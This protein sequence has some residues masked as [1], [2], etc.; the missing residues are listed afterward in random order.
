MPFAVRE[1]S[2]QVEWA[3]ARRRRNSE[4]VTILAAPTQSRIVAFTN[5]EKT[6]LMRNSC[7]FIPSKKW[8]IVFSYYFDVSMWNCLVFAVN[9]LTPCPSSSFLLWPSR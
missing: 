7:V 9:E 1:G 6:P 5:L 3:M 8:I 2:S 4:F